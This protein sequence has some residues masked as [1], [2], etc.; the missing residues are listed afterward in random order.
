MLIRHED[1][2]LCFNALTENLYTVKIND[3]YDCKNI[4]K[5]ESFKKKRIH[6]FLSKEEHKSNEYIFGKLKD[7]I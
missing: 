3:D 7:M 5:A 6:D 4:E 2:K 1:E